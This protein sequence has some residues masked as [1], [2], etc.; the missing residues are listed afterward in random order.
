MRRLDWFLLISCLCAHPL[1]GCGP[2][3]SPAS[4]AAPRDAAPDATADGSIDA[5]PCADLALFTGSYVDWDGNSEA[6]TNTLDTLV[7]EDGGAQ[8][9]VRITAPNGRVVL[10][11]PDGAPSVVTFTHPDYLPLRYTF[12]PAAAGT[13]FD[14]RGLTPARA[15][16][17]FTTLG[18]TRDPAVAQAIV[19]VRR[20]AASPQAVGA[21]VAGARVSLGNASAASFTAASDGTYGA[22]D[23]LAGDAFVLF[24]NTELGG[25][26]A[27]VTVTPPAGVTCVGPDS[28]AV[29][30]GEI[31]VTTFACTGS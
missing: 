19:A 24:T 23:T 11:L 6:P 12:D 31:A 9:S 7:S 4:D 22:G 3:D 29:V 21:A 17:L 5:G 20:E 13:A 8:S 18:V 30:A 28:I 10:C 25:G 14:I 15:D 26:T 1:A 16:E 2:D 27:A